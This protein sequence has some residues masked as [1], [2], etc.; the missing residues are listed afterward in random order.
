VR[1]DRDLYSFSHACDTTR[2]KSVVRERRRRRESAAVGLRVL[3]CRASGERTGEE[4]RKD[5]M[6]TRDRVRSS[7]LLR[8]ADLD[9]LRSPPSCTSFASSPRW[10]SGVRSGSFIMAA[11]ISTV[12]ERHSALEQSV[13]LLC[14][15]AAPVRPRTFWLCVL[16][17]TGVVGSYPDGRRHY[18]HISHILVMTLS[19]SCRPRPGSSSTASTSPLALYGAESAF[20][21][22][23]PLNDIRG[24]DPAANS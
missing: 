17:N 4:E 12:L 10:M 11:F 6:R 3:C 23:S 19:P 2:S 9:S 14:D 18:A 7:R 15:E 1:V 5:R 21:I 20:F 16:S 13:L 24:A 22:C 8:L